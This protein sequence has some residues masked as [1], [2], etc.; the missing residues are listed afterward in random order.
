V[1]RRFLVGPVGCEICGPKF[2]P[3]G[4]AF[5]CGVQ[6][7][8]EFDRKG[9]RWTSAWAKAP[10]ATPPSSWPLGGSAWPRASIVVVTRDDGRQITAI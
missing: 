1:V 6:H 4:M 7:P 5:L 3:D 9:Q 2:T 10:Q 8:G